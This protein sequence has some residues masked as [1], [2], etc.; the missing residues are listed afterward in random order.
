MNKYLVTG[1]CGFIGSNFILY[2]LEKYKDIKIVNLDKLTYCANEENLKSVSNDERYSFIKGDI[3]DKELVTEILKQ[4]NINYI[5]NFAAES[6][7][8]KSIYEPDVFVRTNILGTSNL[9]NCAKEVWSEGDKFKNNV[10]FIQISTD[11][12]YGSLGEEGF[13]YENSPINPH[14]PYSASKASADMIVKSYFDTYKFPINITRCS[15]NYGPYQFTEKLIPLT[16]ERC[17]NHKKI[18]VYGDG[19]NIRDWIYVLDHVKAIDKVINFGRIGE[20]Y[21]IGAHNERNN[22]EIVKKI[23]NYIQENIDCSVNEELIEFVQDRKG[24]DRRYAIDWTKIS[25]EINWKPEMN[26]EEGLK[27]TIDWY[28]DNIKWFI[29]NN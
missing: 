1:G 29:K 21:N 19:M 23:I 15:N 18:P 13:F 22:I 11:E 2:M 7:V 28:R 25:K 12:V 5:V 24:H 8:D 14:S 4:N 20:I 10:K 17:L 3:L 27:K 26:F 9:I 6:H 16:I